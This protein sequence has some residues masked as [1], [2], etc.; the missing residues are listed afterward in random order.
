MRFR[1]LPVNDGDSFLF[2]YKNKFILVDG[3]K[4]KK[5]I[6]HLLKKEKIPKNHLDVLICTH[7]DADHINGILGILE[8]NKYSFKEI[9]LPEIL[10]SISYT[11]SKSLE[12]I[13]RYL[14]D[15]KIINIVDKI[16][17]SMELPLSKHEDNSFEKIDTI[18]LEELTTFYP[19]PW[20]W[21]NFLSFWSPYL[22]KPL[23][24]AIYKICSI[25]RASLL[26]GGYIRW[27]KYS[28]NEVRHKCEYNLIA[29]NSKETGITIYRPIDLLR[30]IYLTTINKES[31]VFLFDS[32]NFPNILFCADSD[33]SFCSSK[34]YL[35]DN[36]IVT[37]PHHGSEENKTA[38]SKINGNNLYFVRS[39]RSQLKRPGPT[40]L[41]QSNKYCTICR[42]KTLKQKVK[43]TCRKGSTVT[44]AVPC[45][46]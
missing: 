19:N 22:N 42:N 35:K 37:A 39:D 32:A 10:G 36:S 7:Y 31:L 16:D 6:I 11:I 18:I 12:E 8:S 41:K 40:Y 25:I 30:A 23:S 14:R 38:Y 29:M 21:N 17:S 27:F 26:S 34:I 46:C 5:H 4:N 9:W 15:G 20:Y 33:L 2:D 3:G 13:L 24:M 45:I 44:S 43:L 28:N 1:A